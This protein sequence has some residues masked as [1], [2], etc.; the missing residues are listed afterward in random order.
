MN[1]EEA[2]KNAPES[3]SHYDGQFYYMFGAFGYWYV[4]RGQWRQYSQ[5]KPKN[6]EPLN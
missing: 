6:A 1:I 5:T 4:H 3:A 2:K